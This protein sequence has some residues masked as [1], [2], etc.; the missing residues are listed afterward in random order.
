VELLTSVGERYFSSAVALGVLH[1]PY[2]IV[3]KQS[4]LADFESLTRPKLQTLLKVD[5]L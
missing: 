1:S 4:L 2:G 3:E 5:M